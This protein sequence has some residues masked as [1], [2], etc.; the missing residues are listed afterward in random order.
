MKWLPVNQYH[1]LS[2]CGKWAISKGSG[3]Y[4]LA[5]LGAKRGDTWEGSEPVKAGTLAECREAA[6]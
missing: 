1:Q 2:A 3:V 5:K 4:L 6:K